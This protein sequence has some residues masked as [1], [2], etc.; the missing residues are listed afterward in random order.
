[1]SEIARRACCRCEFFRLDVLSAERS[2]RCQRMPP[3]PTAEKKSVYPKV[4]REDWCGEFKTKVVPHRINPNVEQ[5][6]MEQ[7]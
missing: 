5:P 4:L 7:L 6:L 3:V 2:G 1:M